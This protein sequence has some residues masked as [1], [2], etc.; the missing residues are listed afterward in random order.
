MLNLFCIV[1]IFHLFYSI[2]FVLNVLIWNNSSKFIPLKSTAEIYTIKELTVSLNM[3]KTLIFLLLVVR[4]MEIRWLTVP[5][6]FH[7]KKNNMIIFF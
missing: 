4:V 1:I 7:D 3:N 5:Y 2:R 6:N